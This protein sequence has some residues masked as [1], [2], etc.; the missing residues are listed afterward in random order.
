MTAGINPNDRTG[1]ILH[2]VA[3][4]VGAVIMVKALFKESLE[5]ACTKPSRRG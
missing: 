4:V 1:V 3:N 5:S 2:A